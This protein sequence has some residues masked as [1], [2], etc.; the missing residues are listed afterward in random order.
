MT[1]WTCLD[2][3]LT[4]TDDTVRL[5]PAGLSCSGDDFLSGTHNSA[6]LTIFDL[7]TFVEVRA[8]LTN[9]RRPEAQ[10]HPA[11]PDPPVGRPQIPWDS[12]HND[13]GRVWIFGRRV[14]VDVSGQ[15]RVEL[16]LSEA[17]DGM[18]PFGEAL[19]EALVDDVVQATRQLDPLPCF[20]GTGCQRSHQHDALTSITRSQHPHAPID[21]HATVYRCRVCSRWWTYQ[22]TGDS[23][24]SYNY[25]VRQF[26]PGS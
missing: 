15:S 9:A 12:F 16:P 20:C 18:E 14:A 11:L 24:Y 25:Q 5:E 17:A 21:H 26:T 2:H 22:E 8:V 3:R 13:Q 6:I 23:H 10:Q 7:M 19:G 4:V 1:T